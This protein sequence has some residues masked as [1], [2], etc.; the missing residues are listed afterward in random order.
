MFQDVVD[1]FDATI[2]VYGPTGAGKTYTMLGPLSSEYE[3]F[4]GSMSDEDVVKKEYKSDG[5]SSFHDLLVDSQG[6][7]PRALAQVRAAAY[8]AVAHCHCLCCLSL[9]SAVSV[10]C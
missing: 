4:E 6:I 2:L 8:A 10:V 7:I 5:G 3:S 1:G 9:P